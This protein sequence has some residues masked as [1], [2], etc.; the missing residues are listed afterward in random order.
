MT[1][2]LCNTVSLYVILQSIAHIQ[3][4]TFCLHISNKNIVTAQ[5]KKSKKKTENLKTIFET[6][7]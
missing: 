3:H 2:F 1:F 5:S 7:T 4:R 6:S